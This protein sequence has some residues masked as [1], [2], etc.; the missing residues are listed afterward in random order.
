MSK[1]PELV[2]GTGATEE[3]TNWKLCMLCQSAEPREDTLVK[4]P[5]TDPYQHILDRVNERASLFDDI[6]VQVQNR[7]QDC[8]KEKLYV[9]KAIWHRNCYS[10]ATNKV[11][12][13]RARERFDHTV[14]TISHC[15]KQRGK[16][17]GRTDIEEPDTS[18]SEFSAPF[19]RSCTLP[20][21]KKQC[22]FCQNDDGQQ[23]FTV[24]TENAGTDLR[25]AVEISR[26]DALRTRL[27][28]CI[29]PGDAHA[30]DVRY[31]KSCWRK[32]VFH[33]LR[34]KNATSLNKENMLQR[35]CLFELILIS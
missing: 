15:I 1:I 22:F 26:D 17:R 35:A 33:V 30:F 34:E 19:T 27:S 24:R 28:T 23:L 29:S 14:S 10:D 31:H 16:K 2:Q 3:Y 7:L 9:K 4:A 8:T 13:Q 11:Q 6:Y 18:T 20:L 21:A 5:R 25:N 32:H 12:I